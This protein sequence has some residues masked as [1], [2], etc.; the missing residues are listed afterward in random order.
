MKADVAFFDDFFGTR[1]AVVSVARDALTTIESQK[2]AAGRLAKA[3]E[4]QGYAVYLGVKPEPGFDADFY[5]PQ[6]SA[7]RLRM[8]GWLHLPWQTIE[9]TLQN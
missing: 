2:Q 6:S 1:V 8:I 5:A 9:L 3:V 7:M 4:L